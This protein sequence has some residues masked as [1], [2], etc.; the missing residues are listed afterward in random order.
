MNTDSVK[1]KAEFISNIKKWVTLET[2]IKKAN[3]QLN[4]WRDEKSELADKIIHYM[5]EKKITDKPI[6]LSDGNIKVV[7]RKIYTSL[8]FGYIEECLDKLIG[9]KEKVDTIIDYIQQNREADVVHEL[10]RT[11]LTDKK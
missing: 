6:G 5:E 8:S 2:Q 3:Q 9:D 10:K 1:E 4:S 11:Y 7:E